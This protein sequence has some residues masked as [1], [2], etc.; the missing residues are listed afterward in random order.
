[1]RNTFNHGNRKMSTSTA[2]PLYPR[3]SEWRQWD[4]H[5]HSPASFH[6][7]G[8]RFTD[9]GNSA[10]D[11]ALIDQMIAALNTAQPAVFALMDYWTFDG[12]FALKRRLKE[13]GAPVLNKKVFPGIEL[14]LAAPTEV[15]LNAHVIFS[16]EI[17]DQD[18]IDFQSALTVEVIEKPLSNDALIKLA[19]KVGDSILNKHGFK[20]P[21][22]Q[23]DDAEALRAG[24]TIAEIDCES[25]KNAIA[26]VPH[27]KAIGFMPYDTSDGLSEVKWE[28]HYAYFLGLFKSSPIFESRNLELRCA[29]V[30]EETEKNAKW[31]KEF[32]HSL[33]NVP[34]L[35][36][37]GSD[38]HRFVGT[39]GDNDKRGYGDYPSGKITWIKADP[40]FRGLQQAIREPSKRSFIGS[41][42]P[43]LI[44]IEQNKTFFIDRVKTKKLANASAVG[45][46]LDGVEVPLNPDLV[47][48]IGNK[49]SGKS[50]LADIVALLGNSRQK[51]HFSFLKKDRFRGRSGDPAKHFVGSLTWCDGTQGADHNLNDDPA[52]DKVEM[53]RYIP[54]NHFE[55]LCNDHVSGRSDAFE[56]ELRSVIFA[57]ADEGTRLGALDFEQLIEQQEAGYRDRLNESR[58]DL[59]KINQEI[60][61]C[62]EQLQPN[63]MSSLKELLALKQQQL[64]EHIKI[65]PALEAKPSDQLT[66]DQAEAAVELEGLLQTEQKL[67]ETEN[68]NKQADAKALTKIRA[69]Q[70]VRARIN[71]FDRA[72]RQF[73]DDT[74]N[75]LAV[76]GI[77]AEDLVSVSIKQDALDK[78][79]S[80]L[81]EQQDA[82]KK[83]QS[84][85]VAKRQEIAD[86]RILLNAKL[87]EPQLRYQS[88][89]RELESWQKKHDEIKGA[90]DIAES[91]D[92]IQARINQISGLPA[93]LETKQKRRLELTAEI[94]DILNEQRKARELL[95]H[96]VHELI[97]KNKLIR[98]EYKLQF[99][100]TLG[101]S[102]DAIANPL[103]SLI[104]QNTGEFRGEDESYAAVKRVCDKYDLNKKEDVLAFVTEL[105]SMVS[106]ASQGGSKT[107][108]GINSVLRKDRTAT[109]VYDLLFGLPFLE[110]KYSLLF[111]DAQ[112]EQLSPGQ[113][114]ALLLIFYLLVDTG[115]NPIILDQPEENLDNET[116]VNLLVPVLTEAKKRRQIIMVTHNPNLAVVCDAEQVI[117]SV[118][119]RKNASQITYTTGSIEW[120]TIN[121]HVVTILEGTKPAFNNRRV[122]YH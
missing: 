95:F 16:D 70:N 13:P 102:S 71:L 18:L 14:R 89:L 45:H 105:H 2:I 29:F 62:E 113:R 5:I 8:Q 61:T 42:P 75:D 66:Q 43:K 34:R 17:D 74:A 107:S 73:V 40:T 121:S 80:E 117:H 118:F 24:S 103:F 116:V 28:Q 81:T 35:V 9:S 68:Q 38:A 101:C 56:R 96:P 46:W 65:K 44:E 33:G 86:K 83:L 22:V 59:K 115:R 85:A 51:Q 27:E 23:S 104:K 36:V 94:F 37:S 39:K 15:R 57:H 12:W 79:S 26:K 58:K 91:V 30:N 90:P 87:N 52:D 50:A 1:M 64:A 69:I 108:V 106:N 111:Q 88:S 32:Q 6:W 76:L 114:G 31:L 19:R 54:Q 100:A 110:P 77:K 112:I 20:D 119:D 84:E 47:A 93:I 48:I 72:F 41:R 82:L 99:L 21:A 60:S 78:A 11:R 53:V 25:Y 98:D 4:L 120:T 92:G 10:A 97:Q 55:G 49:G 122:K 63:V 109:E 7:D 3:G 67:I